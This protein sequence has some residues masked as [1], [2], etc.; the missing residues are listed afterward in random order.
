MKKEKNEKNVI[1]SI[2]WIYQLISI[3]NTPR[4]CKISVAIYKENALQTEVSGQ[5]ITTLNKKSPETVSD[6][7][8]VAY[9]QIP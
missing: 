9:H 1:E 7:P 3:P 4:Y 5:S 8:R 2:V 6:I